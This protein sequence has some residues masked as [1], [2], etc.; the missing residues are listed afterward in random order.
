[1]RLQRATTLTAIILSLTAITWACGGGQNS[2]AALPTETRSPA[3]STEPDTSQDDAAAK[4]DGAFEPELGQPMEVPPKAGRGDGYATLE[5]HWGFTDGLEEAADTAGLVLPMDGAI[6]IDDGDSDT[7]EGIHLISA[8]LFE[9]G[10][11]ATAGRADSVAVV[12][13]GS[14]VQENTGYFYPSISWTSATTTDWDGM[15]VSLKWEE[16]TE[17][18]VTVD[19]GDWSAAVPAGELATLTGTT[20]AGPAGQ[21]LEIGEYWTLTYKVYDLALRWGYDPSLDADGSAD[22]QETAWEGSASV[23]EGAIY[24]M[25][26][27]QFEATAGSPQTAADA[28]DARAELDSSVSFT[29]YTGDVAGKAGA[30]DGVNVNIVAPQGSRPTLTLSV[31]GTTE[32]FRLPEHFQDRQETI[33]LDEGGHFI[34][35]HIHWCWWKTP[36]SKGL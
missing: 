8:L 5:M 3:P 25:G 24:V 7:Q 18:T 9:S 30:I 4:P 33:E 12:E 1:M 31:N 28:L 19:A 20:E 34:T 27:A 29:T 21:T 2:G 32:G 10:G 13:E 36:D 11:A 15:A 16:G 6:A 14:W 26:T 35:G 23:A 22:K 17:P